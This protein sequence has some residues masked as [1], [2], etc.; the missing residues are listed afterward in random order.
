MICP[1]CKQEYEGNFCS[2]CGYSSTAPQTVQI[3][4]QPPKKKHTGCLIVLIIPIAVIVAFAVT[5]KIAKSED[6]KKAAKGSDSMAVSEQITVKDPESES[7][8]PPAQTTTASKPAETTTTAE[9]EPDIS[10]ESY[11]SNSYY[12]TIEAGAYKD[13]LGYTHIVQ[14]VLGK[15]EGT[16]EGTV[17]AYSPDGDVIGKDSN[18]IHLTF[19][20][21]LMD[22]KFS[23]SV[24]TKEDLFTHDGDSNAVKMVDHSVVPDII[25][26]KVYVTLE[27]VGNIGSHSRYK[28]IFYKDDKIVNTSDGSYSIYATKLTGVG[29]TDIVEITVMSA[30]FD[31]VEFFYEK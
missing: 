9:S 6:S 12:D 2:N 19:N 21:D 15:K 23:T 4:Q 18:A 10:E 7:D 13:M 29:S 16:V 1:N 25:G 24:E 31:R 20:A 8:D 14:K 28:L 11:D 27:Q 22:A 26:A 17:I 30:D 5:V 3:V